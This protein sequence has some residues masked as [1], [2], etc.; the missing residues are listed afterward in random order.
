MIASDPVAKKNVAILTSIPG[1]ARTTALAL[2]IEMPELGTLDPKQAA[3]LAGLA[4]QSRQSGRWKGK[5][6]IQG[7]RS[8]VRRALYMPTLVAVRH[9]PD[10]KRKYE[11]LIDVGK[12][13]KLA[14]TACM[15]KLIIIANALI[16]EQRKWSKM[17]A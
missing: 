17:N 14:V 12:P 6:C 5:D 16:R 2:L 7:G 8:I 15:R 9:N 11:Q 4:P 10:L 3:S 1:V 13:A